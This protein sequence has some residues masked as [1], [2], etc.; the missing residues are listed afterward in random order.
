MKGAATL[1]QGTITSALS[2]KYDMKHCVTISKH[3]HIGAKKTVLWLSKYA[4]MRIRPG[5]H[6]GPRWGLNTLPGPSSTSR[7]GRGHFSHT[8]TRRLDISRHQCSID[9]FGA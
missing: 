1:G 2:P 4:K 6:P 8:P 7:L 5:L 3:R 9:S